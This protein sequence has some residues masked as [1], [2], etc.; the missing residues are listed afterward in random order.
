MG[1][2]RCGRGWGWRGRLLIYPSNKSTILLA[3]SNGG[4]SKDKEGEVKVLEE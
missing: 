1:V 3:K 2:Y 4:G